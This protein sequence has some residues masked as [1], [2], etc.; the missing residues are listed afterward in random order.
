MI[1]KDIEIKR[2]YSYYI[3]AAA[4]VITFLFVRDEYPLPIWPTGFF[5]L[6][7]ML[8]AFDMSWEKWKKDG[9]ACITNLDIGNGGHS[10]IHPYD[11]RPAT[12]Y[13]K[14]GKKLRSFVCFATGGFMITAFNIQGGD[15]FIVCPP[16]HIEHTISAMICHTVL[17]KVEF[18]EMPDYV[19]NELMQLKNFDLKKVRVKENLY[20]GM[21]SKIDGTLTESNQIKETE[22]LDKNRE[23]TTLKNLIQDY[24][25]QIRSKNKIVS[26]TYT[27]EV[28]NV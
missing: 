20:F 27:K 12:Q 8:V 4:A 7:C 18:E 5:L 21:C 1:I 6:L 16:E 9:R 3:L 14:D 10:S 22:F 24:Q 19:Q 13:Y 15:Q 11:I 25:E 23:I 28:N 26:G 2:E 17:R